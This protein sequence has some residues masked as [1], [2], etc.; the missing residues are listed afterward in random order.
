MLRELDKSVDEATAA[1]Y[2][3]ALAAEVEAEF[4]KG[5][6]ALGASVRAC[7]MGDLGRDAARRAEEI[8]M[9]KVNEIRRAAHKRETVSEP[10]VNQAP[11]QS[12]L[13]AY[14]LQRR[15]NMER[16]QKHLE[17]LGLLRG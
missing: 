11:Q 15:E 14:E 12:P 6:H 10:A 13:S 3:D 2:K 9:M 5:T 17:K 16:N 4:E 7:R 8:G 1:Q